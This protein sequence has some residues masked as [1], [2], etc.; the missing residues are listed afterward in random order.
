M[1]N[2]VFASKIAMTGVSPIFTEF[3]PR[4]LGG[5]FPSGM[6]ITGGCLTNKRRCFQPLWEF[7]VAFEKGPLI[8]E[9]SIKTVIFHSCVRI[10]RGLQRWSEFRDIREERVRN[11]TKAVILWYNHTSVWHKLSIYV[12]NRRKFRSQTSDNMDRWKA[13]QGRGREK[14]KIRRKKSRRERV[15]RKKMQVAVELVDP[16]AWMARNLFNGI[17][18][19]YD[20]NTSNPIPFYRLLPLLPTN[21]QR[22]DWMLVGT[23][24]LIFPRAVPCRWWSQ[25]AS[26]RLHMNDA[27]WC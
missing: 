13:E 27:P 1:V 7:G 9:L 24:H 20:P 10:T 4:R 16:P 11:Q 3:S 15:R 23:R 12:Y 22:L 8:G 21:F 26:L 19:K 25:L 6:V 2:H 17:H 5:R 18:I 14:R